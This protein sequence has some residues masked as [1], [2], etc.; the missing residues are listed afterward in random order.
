MDSDVCVVIPVFNGRVTVERALRSV[1]HQT[2]PPAQ[3]VVIDDGSRDG[4]ADLVTEFIQANRLR[5]WSLIVQ[6]NGGAASARHAGIRV[7]RTARV[8]LLDAD[9]EWA[10]VKLA[11]SV[12][13]MRELRL[14]IVGA[15]LP[16]RGITAGHGCALLGR[17]A[18]LFSNPYFTSTV[19][20]DREAY[21]EV[22]GFDPMQRHSEDYKLWLA[23][24]WNGKRAGILGQADATYGAA[25]GASGLSSQRWRME[26]S[27]LGNYLGLY[28]SG[29]IGSAVLGAAVACSAAK[30]LLRLAMRR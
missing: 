7:A 17:H 3:V 25:G 23:F 29:H 9:D 5:G 1:Q 30:F 12:T 19:V 6:A 18:M 15:S 22:G 26:R 2:A 8:A 11:N 28:R 20:F 27:E 10:P 13:F 24:A 4:S 14:D 16:R 21:F